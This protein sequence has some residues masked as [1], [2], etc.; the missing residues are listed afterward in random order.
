[1]LGWAR[2]WYSLSY[3][4]YLC[5]YLSR[6]TSCYR[7]Y[8]LFFGIPHS[9]IIIMTLSIVG[10]CCSLKLPCCRTWYWQRPINCQNALWY[11]SVNCFLSYWQQYTRALCCC[12]CIFAVHVKQFH[13]LNQRSHGTQWI[14][15]MNFCHLIVHLYFR[16][17]CR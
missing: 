11:D 1:M 14:F 8:L 15:A 16:W 2:Y 9:I 12:C 5:K 10:L 7:V 6:R 4:F 13:L 17:R 3:I